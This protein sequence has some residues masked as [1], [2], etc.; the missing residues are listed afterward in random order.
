MVDASAFDRTK[1]KGTLFE[2]GV[3]VPLVIAGAGVKRYG[4]R[5][6]S[7]IN[8]VDLFATIAQLAGASES[9]V[10]DSIS[11]ASTLTQA[12]AGPREHNYVEFTSKKVSGWAVRDARYKYVQLDSGEP[13]LFD[14]LSDQ[15]ERQNLATDA[16][17]TA[18]AD[19]LAAVGQSIRSPTLAPIAVSSAST[20]PSQAHAAGEH[21][22]GC[23]AFAATHVGSARDHSSGRHYA[24]R[25][26]ITTTAT[27]CQLSA[28]AIPNHDFN[29]GAQ[30][31]R[32]PVREQRSQLSL[33]RHPTHAAPPTALSLRLDDGVLLNGVK[34]DVLAAGCF[35]VG[36]GRVGCH[37]MNTPWRY[38]P[39]HPAAG[40]SVDSFHAH[41]QPNGAYHYHAIA[42]RLRPSG[43]DGEPNVLGFAA[44]G[45]P[46][47]AGFI[48][49][50]GVSRPVRSSYRLKRGN[51]PNGPG[52]PHD[53]TFRDD[54]EFIAG[55]GDLDEC[56]G[57]TRDGY[58]GYYATDAFPYVMACFR[59]TPDPS[60]AKGA[61]SGTRE[62]RRD[63]QRRP[64]RREGRRGPRSEHH[65]GRGPRGPRRH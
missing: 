19:K 65:H 48:R 58:Y 36:D 45:F 24:S 37:A 35:G 41:T 34:I 57:M 10:H 47:F 21:P 5:D 62:H 11:F 27:H 17:Y 50:N 51:R 16:R 53:G 60:F 15:R 1:A 28:N 3:R 52:G 30:A 33:T 43:S 38:D 13:L 54:Y 18:I 63:G 61:S 26:A 32:N 6:A 14:L 64:P 40:F 8:S 20:A 49:D 31:F 25:V 42:S 2:G 39:M 44:D 23:A 56:N 29:D 12:S 59:G 9:R 46:I 4:E 55:L 22:F 7:L